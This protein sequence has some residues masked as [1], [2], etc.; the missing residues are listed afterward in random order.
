MNSVILKITAV[1]TAII[2]AIVPIC[3]INVCALD[4][5]YVRGGTVPVVFY[6]KDAY[7]YLYIPEID[8][9]VPDSKVYYGKEV[10]FS[11]GSGFFVGKSK[12]NPQYIVTNYHVIDDFI[13]SG[14]GGGYISVDGVS[15][16]SIGGIEYTIYSCIE[17]S[18]CELRVY[19]SDDDYEKAYVD[20]SGDLEKLDLAVLRLNSPTDKR[21]ALKIAPVSESNVGETIYTVGYP[22]NADNTFSSENRLGM[23]AS[24][25]HKGT[26]SRFATNA[27]GVERVSID[28]TIQH[29]NSGGPLV[30]EK[31]YVFGVNTNVISRSPYENQIEA[32]YYS[33]SSNELMTFLD[34]N[35]IPYQK[36]GGGNIQIIVIIA[37]GVV[38]LAIAAVILKKKVFVAGKS[39]APAVKAKPSAP[40]VPNAPSEQAVSTK[41]AVIRSMSAQHN[42]KTFPVG[43]APV[44]IG[45]DPSKC[46]IIFKEGTKGV[47]GVHCS[48]S[49]DSETD[50]FTI[51]DLGSTYGTYL[52]GGQQVLAKTSLNLRSGDSFYVGDKANVCRVE[53]VK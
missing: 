37:A 15:K 27:K 5:N 4:Q 31:G 29:G 35:N 18:S 14:E 28:A 51:T 53:A 2:I 36:A 44:V 43:K 13:K 42:G 34:K 16:R 46:V 40:A 8:T 30:N 39:F 20:C 22:G 48:V 47:S 23:D 7:G 1:C 10:E 52:I 6:L 26:I 12:D 33:I 17:A 25:V 41:K 32:D 38:I 24:T 49:Y 9:V 11:G 21:H 19:Y 50:M 3:S 45:R